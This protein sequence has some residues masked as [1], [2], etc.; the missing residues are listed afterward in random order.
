MHHFLPFYRRILNAILVPSWLS[1]VR[2]NT[3]IRSELCKS[4]QVRS[5]AGSLWS[6]LMIFSHP[7]IRPPP[8]QSLPCRDQR[9]FINLAYYA[10]KFVACCSSALHYFA[11]SWE[12][13]V[14]HHPAWMPFYKPIVSSRS[15]KK[16][17]KQDQQQKTK[18]VTME[19]T[20][21]QV[22]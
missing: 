21:L 12:Q 15:E 1:L 4:Q 11:G 13:D 3:G 22:N 7:A 5:Y 2:V 14:C 20:K 9:A 8:A 6:F 19:M 10:D 18:Q 17:K 16:K